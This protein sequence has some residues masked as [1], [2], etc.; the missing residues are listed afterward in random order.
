MIEYQKFQ[1]FTNKDGEP[2][3]TY[4][5]FVCANRPTV[6]QQCF[7]KGNLGFRHLQ[8]IISPKDSETLEKSLCARGKGNNQLPVTPQ[9]AL[10]CHGSMKDITI[11]SE[12]GKQFSVNAVDWCIYKCKLRLPCVNNIQKGHWLRWSWAQLRWSVLWSDESTF[13]ILKDVVSFDK[14]EKGVCKL[15]WTNPAYCVFY[16]RKLFG[17]TWAPC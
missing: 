9:V 10:H 12:H 1:S 6:K 14:E 16:H 2:F 11:W 7:P 8:P 15:L 13:Q 4:W 17:G 3:T 5:K